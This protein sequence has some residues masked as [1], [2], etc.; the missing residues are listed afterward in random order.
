MPNDTQQSPETIARQLFDEWNSGR[1]TGE[2]YDRVLAPGFVCHGPPGINHSHEP[3]SE[4]CVFHIFR[5]SFESLNFD[6]ERMS[7]EGDRV[8]THFT[9]RGRQV[10]E[11]RGIKPRE[12]ESKF[13]G[14][15]ILRVADGKIAEGWGSLDWG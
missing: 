8:V 9:V 7:T 11:F 10:G 6:V 5:N 14:L 15:T 13:T 1:A 4:N 2:V 3:G 12:P